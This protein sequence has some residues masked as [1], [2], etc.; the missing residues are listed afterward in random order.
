MELCQ[1]IFYTGESN[2]V[3]EM[4]PRRFRI[5]WRMAMESMR[6]W[7][8]RQKETEWIPFLRAITELLQSQRLR[9]PKNLGWPCLW[10]ITT[11][12]PI[13]RRT[14]KSSSFAATQMQSWIQSSGNVRIL[15]KSYVEQQ[16]HG[17]CCRYCMKKWVLPWK[18]PMNFW[19]MSH[20]QPLAMSWI[21]QTKTAF[22]WKRD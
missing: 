12:F 14:G 8:I 22:W 21:W 17:K 4:F 16:S 13:Q 10:P 19:K 2:T 3:V 7:S 5:V 18:K 20:L 11:R 1:P 9:M 15:L 6:I